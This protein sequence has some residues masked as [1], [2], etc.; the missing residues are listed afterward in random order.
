MNKKE[1]E[2]LVLTVFSTW[3]QTLYETDRQ[4]IMR[5]W[6]ALLSDLPYGGVKDSL[7]TLAT[8]NTFM[9]TVGELRRAYINSQPKVGDPPLPAV[10]WGTLV[11]VIKSANSGTFSPAEI[12]PVLSQ[13][14]GLLGDSVWGYHTNG[15]RQEF[16]KVYE[17]QVNKYQQ[18]KFKISEKE[19]QAQDK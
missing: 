12:H 16:Y 14:M 2:E 4:T 7:T 9:P 19:T 18:Q 15:D 8:V 13:T 1:C 3:N 11:G 17:T 6:F 5:A 10:A